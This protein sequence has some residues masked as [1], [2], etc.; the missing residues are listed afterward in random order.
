MFEIVLIRLIVWEGYLMNENGKRK[1]VI[2]IA[3]TLVGIGLIGAAA[4]MAA[5]LWKKNPLEKGLVGL[6]KEIAALHEE[7]GEHFWANAINQIGSENVQA[8]YSLNIGGI[9]EL[10]NITIGLDGEVRRDMEQQ[11]FGT[12]FQVSVANA[13]IAEA[14]FFGTAD[15]LYLQVP[16]VWD[17]S[18]VLDAE[19]ISGQWNESAVK[20]GLQLLTGQELG[21]DRRVDV[22]LFERYYV[23]SYSIIDF[24]L[25]NDKELKMLYKNM[26]VLKMEQAQKKGLLEAGQAESLENYVLEDSD[27]EQIMTTCYLVVLPEKELKEIFADLEGD[28]S[29]AVCLDA[30]K[31]IVRICTLPGETLVTDF[32]EG[33]VSLNLTGAEATID[34]LELEMNGT[35]DM[36]A[37]LSVL[38]EEADFSVGRDEMQEFAE[39]FADSEIRSNMVI[40]RNRE[41]YGSYQGE[42]DVV[43]ADGGEDLWEISLESSVK[44]ERVETEMNPRESGA[45][46][47]QAGTGEKL[48]LDVERFVVKVRNQVVCRG[49]GTAAFAPLAGKVEMPLGKEY[50][51]AEMNQFEAALFMAGC[52]KN[53]YE[54]YGGYLKM[55]K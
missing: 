44:G 27:G 23:N 26:E 36:A 53:V 12:D 45:R 40:E 8:E 35:V 6:S 16:S 10:Q 50:R 51:F 48:S 37:L 22:D 29:L 21:I 38:S 43:L 46:G 1:R 47:E 2:I 18:V 15:T 33:E 17:G 14:S 52:V 55:L 34:R 20:D 11:L 42:C 31:R 3:C 39:L 28:I 24:F 19:D 9:P 54:N 30:G 13:N 49:S 25:K 7:L 32:W 5:V 4:I 41:E